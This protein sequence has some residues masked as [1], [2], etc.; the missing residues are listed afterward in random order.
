MNQNSEFRRQS[1]NNKKGHGKAPQLFRHLRNTNEH[2]DVTL[3]KTETTENM[4]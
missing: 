2:Y 4:M 3:V 1:S